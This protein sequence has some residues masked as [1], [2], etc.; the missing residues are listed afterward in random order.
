[1]TTTETTPTSIVKVHVVKDDSTPPVPSKTA[2]CSTKT[3][4]AGVPDNI[5][6]RSDR[7]QSATVSVIA[8]DQSITT[9]TSVGSTG[10]GPGAGAVITSFTVQQSGLYTLQWFVKILTAGVNSNN[11]SLNVGAASVMTSVEGTGTGIYSQL[12]WSGFI[13]AGTVVSATIIASDATGN[14]LAQIIASGTPVNALVVL[15]QNK[16]D[17][18]AAQNW[19]QNGA[20]AGTVLQAGQQVQMFHNDDMWLVSVGNGT[21]C[22]VSVEAEY[23]K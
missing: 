16:G 14:Y 10:A 1:M 13:A 21:P 6:T 9:L 19:Q 23:V 11:V 3:Y 2:T 18:I 22:F 17:A 7:R 5:L 15:C 8:Q 4:L 20:V 12:S